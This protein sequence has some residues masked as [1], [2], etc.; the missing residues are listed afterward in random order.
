MS[1][2]ESVSADLKSAESKSSPSAESA[3]VGVGSAEVAESAAY[4]KATRED[5][6]VVIVFCFTRIQ[7]PAVRLRNKRPLLSIGVA[8]VG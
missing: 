5:E 6:L 1:R 7:V 4:A 8:E 3:D 2:Y